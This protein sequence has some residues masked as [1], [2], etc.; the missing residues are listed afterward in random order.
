VP[1]TA[2]LQQRNWPNL[3]FALVAILSLIALGLYFVAQAFGMVAPFRRDRWDY[4]TARRPW[5]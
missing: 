2:R 4:R 3:L 1:V 5:H